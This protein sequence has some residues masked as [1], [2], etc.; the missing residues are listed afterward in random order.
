[1]KMKTIYLSLY[2]SVV[3]IT[4]TINVSYAK[5]SCLEISKNNVKVEAWLSKKYEK[6]Y[7]DIKKEFKEMGRARVG[8]F[9][10]PAENPSRIVAIGRCV[11]VHLAQHFL[12]KAEKYSIGTTHLVNQGFVSSHWSGLGSSLFSENSM[13]PITQD[14]LA[15]LMKENL[16]TQSF[17]AL[18][19]SFTV[20]K[21]KV[22]AFG[23]ILDNPKLLSETN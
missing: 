3:F 14:Q 4:S 6:N 20:Q 10:Y 17:H 7:F 11:P 9:I 16:D 8:L 2:V 5:D 22:P 21:K 13:N 18:Y 23:L 19:K 12:K 1:M 15:L